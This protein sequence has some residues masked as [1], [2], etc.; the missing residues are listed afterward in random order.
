MAAQLDLMDI[1]ENKTV[2][3]SNSK[4]KKPIENKKIINKVK[5]HIGYIKI[6]PHDVYKICTDKKRKLKTKA[7]Y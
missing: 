6:T 7:K 5:N 1:F 3:K 2:A 4:S